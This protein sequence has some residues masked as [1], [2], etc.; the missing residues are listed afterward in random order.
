MLSKT[1][2]EMGVSCDL[3]REID[4]LARRKNSGWARYVVGLLDR[5]LRKEARK[6]RRRR[7]TRRQP[8]LSFSFEI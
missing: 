2:M 5:K 8:V 6:A 3:L 1:V 4:R 7:R